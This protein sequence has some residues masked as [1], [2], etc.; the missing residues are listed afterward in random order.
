[1]PRNTASIGSGGSLGRTAKHRA[2]ALH[3]LWEGR[4]MKTIKTLF[5]VLSVCSLCSRTAIYVYRHF[6]PPVTVAGGP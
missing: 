5:I 3:S 4:R 1:L 6:N 2:A